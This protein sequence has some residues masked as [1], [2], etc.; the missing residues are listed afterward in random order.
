MPD[1]AA[2]VSQK[3]DPIA[4]FL[5]VGDKGSKIVQKCSAGVAK[6]ISLFEMVMVL[7][8]DAPEVG[9]G[10]GAGLVGKNDHEALT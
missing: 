2:H 6:A 3:Q 7:G 5:S 1:I 8:I 4:H 9:Y 10:V